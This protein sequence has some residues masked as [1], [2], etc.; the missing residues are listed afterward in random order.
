MSLFLHPHTSGT[1]LFLF[2]LHQN[3]GCVTWTCKHVCLL[4]AIS[5]NIWICLTGDCIL[6]RW[7]LL[8]AFIT[9]HFPP[10]PPLSS[11]K[12]RKMTHCSLI[13]TWGQTIISPLLRWVHSVFC[14]VFIFKLTILQSCPIILYDFAFIKTTN[15]WN[16]SFVGHVNFG[17]IG[18][19][20]HTTENI[21]IF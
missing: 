8:H 11:V 4:A 18:K 9:A 20:I 16:W 6:I 15:K 13:Q 19:R 21:Y 7:L 12:P 3:T 2:N 1:Y 17:L 10:R 5:A 14:F